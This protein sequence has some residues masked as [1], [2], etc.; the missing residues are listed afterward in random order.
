MTKISFIFCLAFTLFTGCMFIFQAKGWNSYPTLS[1]VRDTVTVAVCLCWRLEAVTVTCS[2]ENKD[3]STPHP[4]PL[5]DYST[6]T[7]C[8]VLYTLHYTIH[9]VI[10]TLNCVIHTLNCVIHTLHSVIHTIHCVIHTLHSVIHTI[11][12][13]IHTIHSVIHTQHSPHYTI[14]YVTQCPAPPRKTDRS[15]R[16]TIGRRHFLP[17]F[18]RLFKWAHPV[19]EHGYKSRRT[20]RSIRE[21]RWLTLLI[22]G[23]DLAVFSSIKLL[24]PT[25]EVVFCLNICSLEAPQKTTKE[26]KSRRKRRFTAMTRMQLPCSRL[27]K[28]HHPHHPGWCTVF[29]VGVKFV[30]E[31]M[32]F[33]RNFY[34][35]SQFGIFWA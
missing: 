23:K 15:K 28:C 34:L 33:C 2:D 27:G 3:Q 22:V 21:G 24:I 10:H 6:L 8:I 19:P 18:A 26:D 35:L 32:V 17:G 5:S 12:C 7:V 14:L 20:L 9:F 29:R 31:H 25:K 1:Y 30:T 4:V 13:V 16:R 11:H